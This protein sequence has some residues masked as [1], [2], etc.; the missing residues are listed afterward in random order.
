MR[1]P[2]FRQADLVETHGEMWQ[3]RI[4]NI[5]DFQ[6]FLFTKSA[7]NLKQKTNVKHMQNTHTWPALVS[8]AFSHN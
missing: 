5:K 2:A 7:H 6:S 1:N 3:R 4:G 8:L